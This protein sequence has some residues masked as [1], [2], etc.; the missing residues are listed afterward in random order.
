VNELV[1]GTVAPS[2]VVV[3]ETEALFAL[4][5][6][7]ARTGARQQASELVRQAMALAET[8]G[9]P[10]LLSSVQLDAANILAELGEVER[11]VLVARAIAPATT[12]IT[13]LRQIQT[14]LSRAG[15]EELAVETAREIAEL[16]AG[17]ETPSQ[18]A[19]AFVTAA[20]ALGL[21]NKGTEAIA[22]FVDGVLSAR[23]SDRSD[24]FRAVQNGAP[25]LSAVDQ[26]ETLWQIHK[27]IS[28]VDK[29][30]TTAADR[31]PP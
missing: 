17:I 12:K 3:N 28:E 15:H 31:M 9:G 11:A 24:V 1:A 27:S 7:L 26:R 14:V 30:W 2:K 8:I 22:A 6:A 23:L 4:A 29:W 10:Q 25:L 19:E 16:A 20:M 18:S 21:V 5:R 13:A